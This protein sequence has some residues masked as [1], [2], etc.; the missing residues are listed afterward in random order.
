MILHFTCVHNVESMLAFCSFYLPVTATADNS[1]FT[2]FPFLAQHRMDHQI[3]CEQGHSLRG[4]KTASRESV[5]AGEAVLVP[6]D[7]PARSMTRASTT[8]T[9]SN[10]EVSS[11]SYE[12]SSASGTGMTSISHVVLCL[13]FTHC[14]FCTCVMCT[15]TVQSCAFFSFRVSQCTSS[16]RRSRNRIN[17]FK[18]LTA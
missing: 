12:S 7:T 6:C 1:L 8:E 11:S 15:C 4:R 9:S 14:S 17:K 2:C 13:V 10:F 18:S 3:V 5:G 16:C